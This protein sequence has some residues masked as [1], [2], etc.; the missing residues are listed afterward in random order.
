MNLSSE[1]QQLWQSDAP[2][3]Q[4]VG[5]MRKAQRYRRWWV[6]QR[7]VEAAATLYVVAHYLTHTGSEVGHW[8]YMP[9]VLAFFP[10]FWVL[11]YKNAAVARKHA[12]LQPASYLQLRIEQI[13][14]AMREIK[15]MFVTAGALLAYAGTSWWV[16]VIVD[17]DVESL[18]AAR[19]L[20]ALTVLASAV[21]ATLGLWR[22]RSQ[23][24]ELAAC[25]QA[26]RE[27]TDI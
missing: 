9:I 24:R 10:A 13:Q 3:A 19:G 12:A 5:I 22:R 21:I 7:L 4:V 18:M 25:R 2:P 1:L 15:F 20:M 8:L 16:M 26:L 27:W 6:A 14:G 11:I 23:A 17:A